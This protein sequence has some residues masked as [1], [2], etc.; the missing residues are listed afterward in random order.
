M[1]GVHRPESA[2]PATGNPRKHAREQ[3]EIVEAAFA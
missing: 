3:T 2:S 1:R